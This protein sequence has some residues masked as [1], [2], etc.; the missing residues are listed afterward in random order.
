MKSFKT[1]YDFDKYLVNEGIE[2]A[3][4]STNSGDAVLALSVEVI[5]KL[6]T[7]LD[8][9]SYSE[10]LGEPM[11]DN[12]GYSNFPNEIVNTGTTCNSAEDISEAF[13]YREDDYKVCVTSAERVRKILSEGWPKA[14]IKIE[15]F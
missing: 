11:N 5:D 2:I 3:V 13:R 10:L 15:K 4:I 9:K 8:S 7:S 6:N 12:W 14:G 1:H